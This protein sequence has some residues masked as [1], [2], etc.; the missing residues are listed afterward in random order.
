MAPSTRARRWIRSNVLG[1][2]ALFVVLGGVAVAA[3]TPPANSVGAKQLKDGSIQPEHIAP[4]A[5]TSG[6]IKDRTVQTIDLGLNV[7]AENQL[8]AQVAERL[9]DE[10]TVETH[11]IVDEA[12]SRAK[13][14]DNA[15]GSFEVANNSLTGADILDG[16]ITSA[17]LA[18]G[19]GLADGSVTTAKL[20][21][22]AVTSQKIADNVVTASDL[23]DNAVATNE[24]VNGAVTMPKLA[25]LAVTNA[26]LADDS[27]T[28]AKVLNGTLSG[29]D[30]ANAGS[31]SDDVNAD[32]LDGLSASAFQTRVTGTCPASTAVRTI[33]AN[34]SVTC[35][36]VTGGSGGAIA[37]GSVTTAKIADGAVT[38]AKLANSSVGSGTIIDASIAAVDLAAN[39]VPSAAIQ[40]NAVGSSEIADNAVGASELATPP[41]VSVSGS[42]TTTGVASFSTETFDNGSMFA[43]AS[44]TLVTIP[45]TGLYQVDVTYDVDTPGND[46]PKLVANVR[47]NSGG[48]I[49]VNVSLPDLEVKIPIT[50]TGGQT[51]HS[52]ALV[53][54]SAGDQVT[55]LNVF[56]NNAATVETRAQLYLVTDQ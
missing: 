49:P 42:Q 30:I 7:V 23:A 10:A 6:G 55:F 33:E 52:A 21:D 41:S 4:G 8:T 43:P 54:L 19:V 3:N 40:D 9:L 34:G 22:N 25:D 37:D 14:A 15:V 27:V 53:R 24:I 28:A 35:E 48:G 20:A 16:S 2:V 56:T 18:A 39:S 12:V 38:S 44:P 5:V 47:R 26:K 36:P 51:Y 29:A 32:L 17:D 31:G 13:L 46:A 11:H 50:L 45:Q 1:F